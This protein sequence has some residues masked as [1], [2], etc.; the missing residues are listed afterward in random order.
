MNIRSRYLL[1]TLSCMIII[2]PLT[3]QSTKKI[4]NVAIFI[5]DGVEVLDFTGPGEVFSKAKDSTENLFNVYTVAAGKKEI[6]SNNFLRIIPNYSIEDCPNADIIILP[7]GDTRIPLADSNVIAWIIN[8]KKRDPII[9]S[10]CTG[11]FLLAKAG[12]LDGKKATTHYCCQEGLAEKYPKITVV[13]GIRFVDNGDI[14]TTEGISAGIDGS[15]HLVSRLY[16][17]EIARNTAKY[18]MYN[19]REEVFETR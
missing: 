15:L 5:H 3:A 4:M 14:L 17:I 12:L 13:R 16:G 11:A 18:M 19:W 1:L 6:L 9:M 10:V 7:G 8:S 2:S